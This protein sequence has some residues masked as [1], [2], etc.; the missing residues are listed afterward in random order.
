MLAQGPDWLVVNKPSGLAVHRS[1]L[2]GDRVSLVEVARDQ[3]G[4]HAHPV[5]RLD[6]AAS[7]CLL[8]ALD[9][10]AAA[11]LQIALEQA[12]KRYL[13]QVRGFFRWD[14]PFVVRRPMADDKGIQRDAETTV[15]V[16]GRA[17]TPRSSLLR[18]TLHTGRYHQVRR[19]VRDLSHPVI[20]DHQHGDTRANRVWRE[21]HG[22]PRLALHAAHLVVPDTVDVWAPPPDDL[23]RVW[24]AQPWWAEAVAKEPRLVAT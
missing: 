7:G 11:R 22:L 16:L 18:A 19:H 15:E 24:E 10:A 14:D 4:L 12:S 6:R 2:V 13:V 21:A 3:L 9:G 5:H 23:R 1:R 20:G 8:L 17:H